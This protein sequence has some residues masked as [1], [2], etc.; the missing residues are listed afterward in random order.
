M[1]QRRFPKTVEPKCPIEA[2]EGQQFPT[3]SPLPANDGELNGTRR[4]SESYA[5]LTSLEW[6]ITMK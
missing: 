4:Y 1:L 3:V 2:I 6:K 5:T